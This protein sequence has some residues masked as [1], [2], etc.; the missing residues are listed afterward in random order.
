LESL[1]IKLRTLVGE[2]EKIQEFLALQNQDGLKALDY[3][4]F[5]NRHDMAAILREFVETSQQIVNIKAYS[6]DDSIYP[7]CP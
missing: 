7:T 2:K 6:I 1:L 4:V 5:K 3:C